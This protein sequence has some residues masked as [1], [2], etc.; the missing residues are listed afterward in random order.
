MAT[1]NNEYLLVLLNTYQ[2]LLMNIIQKNYR[3]IFFQVIHRL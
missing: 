3:Y 1:V 2:T